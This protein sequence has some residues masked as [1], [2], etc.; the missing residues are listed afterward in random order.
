MCGFI[1]NVNDFPL[2]EPL[3]DI[4]GYD[5]DSIREIIREQYLRPTATVINL[6]PTRT[7]PQLLPA[8]W[9][10]AT[11][12]DGSPDPRYAS[13]NSRAGKLLTSPLHTKPPR[14]IRSIVVARGFCEWQPIYKGG[15]TY[16]QLP[17]VANAQRLPTPV[18]KLQM[19]IEPENK[20]LL[21]LGAV[22]KLRLTPEGQPKI[23]TAVVTLPPH[24][25]FLDVHHKS[26]PL[27]IKHS[28]L[29]DWL[30]P[31]KPTQDFLHLF[32]QTHVR[33]NFTVTPVDPECRP[34]GDTLMTLTPE[35]DDNRTD[36]P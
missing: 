1:Y 26:F 15:Y 30:N 10:L 18:K 33:E 25:D 19:L 11:K 29:T 17:G 27:V 13:F 21:L 2:L 12:P 6:V 28:E 8:T 14:S 31:K 9:W 24:P 16:T 5:E 22:S 34:T 36:C 23:N 3:L 4:A 32:E 35:T 7:G 20:G